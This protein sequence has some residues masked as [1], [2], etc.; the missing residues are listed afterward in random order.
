[1]STFKITKERQTLFNHILGSVKNS[2]IQTVVFEGNTYHF[3]LDYKLPYGECHYSRI[4]A[5]LLYLKEC[6]GVIKPGDNL[7]E[8]TSGSGGRAAASLAIALGYKITIAIPAG[9]EKAREDAITKTGAQLRLT[10]AEDYVNGFPQFIKMFL[11]ENPGSKYINHVMGNIFGRGSSINYVALGAFS[12][13]VDEVL[14]AGISPD[15]VICPLGNGTTTVPL[16]VFKEVTGAKIIGFESASAAMSYRKKY[17]GKYEKV[18]DGVNPDNFPR[19]NLP[20]TSPAK[21]VFPMP[22]L[23]SALDLLDEICLVTGEYIDNIF[24]ERVG[25]IPSD[26]DKNTIKWDTFHQ[27]DFLADFGRTGRAGFGVAATLAR[28]NNWKEKNILIPVF[29][30]AWHYDK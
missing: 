30:A 22:A 12:G 15:I 24:Q 3:K 6:L 13:F 8:T 19:H 16:A 28:K 2:P 9:G 1:M 18:F 7:L 10:P 11:D 14:E 27:Q 4:F 21:T 25:F 29:D 5:K 23:S 17:P 26:R 20:G